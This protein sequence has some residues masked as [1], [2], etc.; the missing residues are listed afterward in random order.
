MPSYI[1]QFNADT[2]KEEQ[3]KVKK[4]V[5]DKGGKIL[6]EYSLMGGFSFELPADH[7][8]TLDA[9]PCVQNVEADSTV[10]TQ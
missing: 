5:L 8:Q 4:S 3:E 7:I 1:L 2:P 9:F 10:S 6:H